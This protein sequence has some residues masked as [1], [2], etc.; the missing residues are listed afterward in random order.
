LATVEEIVIKRYLI[1]ATVERLFRN[2]VN[3]GNNLDFFYSRINGDRY[4]NILTRHIQAAIAV[5]T[6]LI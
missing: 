2:Q 6:T 5:L 4:A 1:D 3:L